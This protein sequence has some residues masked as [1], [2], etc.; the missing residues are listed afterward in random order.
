MICFQCVALPVE[1][2]NSRKM[3]QRAIVPRMVIQVDS[4]LETIRCEME[5][6]RR[7]GLHDAI[8]LSSGLTLNIK[9]SLFT[10]IWEIASKKN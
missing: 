1:L 5:S 6:W 3:F 10:Q 4:I 2:R 7:R 8:E 9:K